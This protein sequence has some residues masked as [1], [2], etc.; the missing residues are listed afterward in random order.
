MEFAAKNIKITSMKKTIKYLLVFV[1]FGLLCLN[2]GQNNSYSQ[3]NIDKNKTN[4]KIESA[5]VFQLNS[6]K[7]NRKFLKEDRSYDKKGNLNVLNEYTEDGCL[8]RKYVSEFDSL[9][10]IIEKYSY[11]CIQKSFINM[12]V[13][14]IKSIKSLIIL[15]VMKPVVILKI[16]FMEIL[17]NH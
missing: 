2:M 17:L 8:R 3:N 4:R 16:S 10:K 6:K 13:L 1:G 14:E 15:K 5:K 12:I 9:G 7:Q 11:H